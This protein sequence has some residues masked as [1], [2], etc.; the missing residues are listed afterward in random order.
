MTPSKSGSCVTGGL[1][2]V[3]SQR[4]AAC[5][6]RQGVYRMCASAAVEDGHGGSHK[7]GDYVASRRS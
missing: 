3:A 4:L 7:S 1:A 6:G 5:C 2:L